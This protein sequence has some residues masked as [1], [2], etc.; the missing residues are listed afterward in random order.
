IEKKHLY[1]LFGIVLI[2]GIAV[3]VAAQTQNNP[4]HMW[5]EMDCDTDF[6]VDTSTGKVGIGITD[7]VAH[8]HVKGGSW[9]GVIQVDSSNVGESSGF[10]WRENNV[11]KWS[12]YN[13]ATND[14]LKLTNEGTTTLVTVLQDGNVGIGTASPT[15]PLQVAGIVHST[16]GGF[17]FPDNTIQITA[18]GGG[19]TNI[20]AGQGL[21]G[22]GPS[23]EVTLNVGSGTGITLAQNGLSV[24]C[25]EVLGHY[26]GYDNDYCTGGTCLGG[27]ILNG[28]LDVGI[29][30]GG[31]L[32][33]GG[34][35]QS[36]HVVCVKGTG[37]LGTC[38]NQPSSTGTC[39]CV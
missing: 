20:V 4:G 38:S 23:G 7:P 9:T 19:I 14:A 22:G 32:R 28:H 29:N 31:E 24:D 35:D 33:V 36:S 37:E 5:D 17:K 34:L 8:L 2:I 3:F 30:V 18:G 16:S 6:C 11:R 15:S 21:I 39:T 1:F 12:L 25:T 13:Y 10:G 26:C 27:L